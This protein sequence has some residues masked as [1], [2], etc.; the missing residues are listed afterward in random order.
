MNGVSAGA[1]SEFSEGKLENGRRFV[2][3]LWNIGR[4]VLAQVDARPGA[5][6]GPIDVAPRG[7][8]LTEA[9]RWI[10]SRT[11]A[12]VEELTR[13]IEQY[14]FGEYATALQQF[15]WAELAD[16]YIELAKPQRRP[17]GSED[18]AVRTLAYVLD[19][20]LRL[21]HPS[22][23]FVT[24]TLALQLREQGR[25]SEPA[26]S[27]VISRWPTPGSRDFGLEDRF[28][29]AIEVIRRI[30]E[31]RQEAGVDSRTKVRIALGGDAASLHPFAEIIASLTSAEVR[32]GGGDTAP[33]LVRAV[34]VRVDVP[35]DVGADR[36]R[37]EKELEAALVLLERSRA[38]LADPNFPIRAPAPVVEKAR[39][40]L[41]EREAA[42]ASLRA[43]LAK[44]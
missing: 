14:Q 2:N 12:A 23:P 19:R 26:P 17:A 27:L 34:E 42:V 24:D 28:G 33:T 1:D 21:A 11:E 25:T 16:V 10:L 35:G 37:V 38:L 44:T 31:R 20:V 8:D 4:F 40:A 29:L 22:I 7:P 6:A 41:A 13:L 9:D 30:R 36:A 3:K 18:A 5:F 15:V 39:A 43:E 32:F